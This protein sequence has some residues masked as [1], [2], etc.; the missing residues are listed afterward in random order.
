VYGQRVTVYEHDAAWA[1]TDVV[2]ARRAYDEALSA[3]CIQ[4]RGRT[5]PH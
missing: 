2:R 4:G 1:R 3:A 5:R